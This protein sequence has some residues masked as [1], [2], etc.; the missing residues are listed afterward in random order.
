VLPV[1]AVYD[2]CV[3]YPAV[4]RDLLMRLAVAGLVRARWTERIHDEWMRSVLRDRPDLRREDLERTRRLMDRHALDALVEGDESSIEGI[5]LPDS[6]DRHV[7]AAAVRCGATVIVTSNL[8]DFPTAVLGPLG[9]EARGPDAFAAGLFESDAE[10]VIGAVRAQRGAL[11][12]PVVTAE[13]ML[14]T[15]ERS[16]LVRTAGLLRGRVGEW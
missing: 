1:T 11:R 4:V 16:G 15:F 9:I 5:G 6:D 3:L 13:G 10:G 12:D 14:V 7:V 2:A 8:R